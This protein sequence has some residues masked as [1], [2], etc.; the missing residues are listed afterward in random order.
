MQWCTRSTRAPLPSRCESSSTPFWAAGRCDPAGAGQTSTVVQPADGQLGDHVAQDEQASEQ[1]ERPLARRDRDS[2][3]R[4]CL[5]R[6]TRSRAEASRTD[7]SRQCRRW[8]RTGRGSRSFFLLWDSG[9][10]RVVT[11]SCSAVLAV[12][13]AGWAANSRVATATFAD[14]FHSAQEGPY[15][16]HVLACLWP[17]HS[18]GW[19]WARRR[20]CAGTACPV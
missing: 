11:P 8:T 19:T 17:S 12:I 4:T 20:R 10:R 7:G 15:P 3:R 9:M 18:R 14:P 2:T 13:R 1:D 6:G 5:A 16:P